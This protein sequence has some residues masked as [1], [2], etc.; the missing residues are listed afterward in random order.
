[1]SEILQ[2]PA[3][4]EV[5]KVGEGVYAVKN[6]YPSN[7]DYFAIPR[8]MVRFRTVR[9]DDGTIVIERVRAA[10]E[11]DGRQAKTG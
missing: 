11:S 6:A 10:P 5:E 3:K 4:I 2:A 8:D 1:M 7:P 9:K